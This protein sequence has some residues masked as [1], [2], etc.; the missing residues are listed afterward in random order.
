MSPTGFGM[1]RTFDIPLMPMEERWSIHPSLAIVLTRR[2]TDDSWGRIVFVVLFPPTRLHSSH[3]SKL[4]SRMPD[5]CWGAGASAGADAGA[6]A[7]FLH[8]LMQIHVSPLRL[9]SAVP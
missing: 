8:N 1:D 7:D 9:L 6:R 5:S 4:A 2:C 3:P